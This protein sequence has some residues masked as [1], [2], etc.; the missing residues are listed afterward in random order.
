LV[1]PSPF[2]VRPPSILQKLHQ[3]ESIYTISSKHFNMKASFVTVAALA[4]LVSSASAQFFSV[5]AAHSGS[6]IHLQSLNANGLALWI[7]KPTASFC[8]K[9]TVG[10]KNCPKG[11]ETNFAGGD[12]GLA[13]GA[14]VPGGQLVYIDRTTGALG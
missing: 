10:A 13:M 11:K 1:D 8:P 14:E 3:S 7:G 5:I 9:K 6:P 2:L 4:G 12:G